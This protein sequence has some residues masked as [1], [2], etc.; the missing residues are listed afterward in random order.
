MR[1]NKI[2]S[3]IWAD[4][5]WIGS[6]IFKNFANQDWFCAENFHS[7]FIS[8]M[9]PVTAQSDGQYCHGLVLANC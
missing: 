8:A 9:V 1:K 3:L 4:Q 5:D 6:M 2:H 7:L